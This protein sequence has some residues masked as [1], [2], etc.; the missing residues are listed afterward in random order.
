MGARICVLASGSKGNC[1]YISDGVTNL[2]IDAGLVCKRLEPLLHAKGV[3]LSSI[4]G[5]L[6]THEHTD[7][8]MGLRSIET[9]YNIPIYANQRTAASVDIRLHVNTSKWIRNDFE[10]GFK[11]GTIQV[12]PFRTSH[13]A[14]NSVGFS[15][16]VDGKKISYVTDLGYVTQ[17]VFNAVKGS[18]LVIL[19]ANH[20]LKML[21]NGRYPLELQARI[22]SNTGHLS[23]I[24]AAEVALALA[25]SG[26]KC[27]ILAHLSEENNTPELA[28][29]V[30]YDSLVKNGFNPGKNIYL[31]VATQNVSTP[32]VT[33]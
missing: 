5:I 31:M 8:I 22:K 10:S 28:W 1:T 27:I 9:K 4:N 2:L 16:I 32:M 11:L 3:E 29:G 20:D 6:V 14:V 30:C 13:D 17:G 15:L 33:L 23:N 26:T 24:Q 18:D 21:A 19:E 7:H 25:K 12:I